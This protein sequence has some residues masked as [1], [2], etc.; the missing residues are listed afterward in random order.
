MRIETK[1]IIVVGIVLTIVLIG[2]I[3][4]ISVL[5]YEV[6][7]LQSGQI[8]L[9][10]YLEPSD[11]NSSEVTILVKY[12]RGLSFQRCSDFDQAIRYVTTIKEQVKGE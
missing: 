10:N 9:Q 7:A 4:K 11:Y 1:V 5:E 6:K 2:L 8:Y 3:A 12:G